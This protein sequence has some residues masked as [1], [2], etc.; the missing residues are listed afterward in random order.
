MSDDKISKNEL[1]DLVFSKRALNKIMALEI[2][3]ENVAQQLEMT[4]VENTE[5]KE[6]ILKIARLLGL[7]DIEPDQ[8]INALKNAL[9][10]EHDSTSPD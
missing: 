2:Q 1:D 3:I 5:S 6:L 8:I 9:G 10:S 4:I 7:N